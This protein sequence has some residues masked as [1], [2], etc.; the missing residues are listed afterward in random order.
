MDWGILNFWKWNQFL[1]MLLYKY[2][3]SR[4][5]T[6]NGSDIIH[7]AKLSL[8]QQSRQEQVRSQLRWRLLLPNRKSPRSGKSLPLLPLRYANQLQ[9][10]HFLLKN[11]CV[12]Q[13]VCCYSIATF[14][15][16]RLKSGWLTMLVWMLDQ[17]GFPPANWPLIGRTSI[18]WT[19]QYCVVK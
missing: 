3:W 7:Q 18:G 1:S 14:C 19:Y 5:N 17:L 6:R 2:S 13:M 12:F 10:T 11:D 4:R 8:N 16:D 15:I 9:C